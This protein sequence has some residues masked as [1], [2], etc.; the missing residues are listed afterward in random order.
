MNIFY[1]NQPC[2]GFITVVDDT[3]MKIGLKMSA[4]VMGFDS[5]RRIMFMDIKTLQ[6]N[7]W[8][9]EA[10]SIMKSSSRVEIC[11]DEAQ[12]RSRRHMPVDSTH[13]AHIAVDGFG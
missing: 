2:I 13:E 3:M 11:A 10:V 5:S 8:L 12:V 9:G 1:T 4:E 7:K 6:I